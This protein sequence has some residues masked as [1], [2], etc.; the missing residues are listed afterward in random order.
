MGNAQE[1]VIDSGGFA[2]LGGSHK[3][4]IERCDVS[5]S[6]SHNGLADDLTGFRILREI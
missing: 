1:L 4:P 2:V 3:T 6:E 5:F